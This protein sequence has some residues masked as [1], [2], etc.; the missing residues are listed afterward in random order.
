M[1]EDISILI[2]KAIENLKNNKI[3]E[4]ENIIKKILVLDN[5][6]FEA[7]NLMGIIMGMQNYHSEARKFFEKSI[8]INPKN[9][10][11]NF[12][13]AKTLSELDEDHEA[14][15]YFKEA[16]QLDK[17]YHDAFCG[18]GMSLFKLNK[19]TEALEAYNNALN[20][21]PRSIISLINK[22]ILLNKIKR[23]QEAIIC[24]DEVLKINLVPQNSVI[25]N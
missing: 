9:I 8:K 17:N 7:L 11:T 24:C 18:Y 13:L 1:R 12:N 25:I 5:S 4:A 14:V 6:N 20:I 2:P 19:F 22:A 10:L 23:N 16:I 21:H 3:S 15:V